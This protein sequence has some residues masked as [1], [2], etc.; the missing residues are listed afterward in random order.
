MDWF[1]RAYDWVERTFF[2]TVTRK[3]ASFLVVPLIASVGFLLLYSLQAR[4]DE[5]LL[6][7]GFFA[8]SATTDAK[9]ISPSICR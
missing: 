4:I 7:Q 2:T 3:F 5:L 6:R 8:P 1:W 9:G